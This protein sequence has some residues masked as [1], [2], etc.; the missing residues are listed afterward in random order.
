LSQL[1]DEEE[2]SVWVS[3][4]TV[5]QTATLIPLP[6]LICP[7]PRVQRKTAET[8]MA[9]SGLEAASVISTTRGTY[10]HAQYHQLARRHGQRKAIVAVASSL[11]VGVYHLLTEQTMC[12]P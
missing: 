2:I 3:E 4:E 8:I 1:Y 7:I 12:P 5:R 6:D 9:E 10:L 11:L